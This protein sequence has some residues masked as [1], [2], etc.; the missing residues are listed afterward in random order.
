MKTPFENY[1][2]VM[3]TGRVKVIHSVG[4][5]A[6]I[7]MISLSNKYTGA[8]SETSI[9]LLRA[10]FIAKPEANLAR[11]GIALKILRSKVMSAN[12]VA[13]NDAAGQKEFD[14]FKNDMKNHVKSPMDIQLKIGS[15]KFIQ[16]TNC[17]NTVGLMDFSTH[18]RDGTPVTNFKYPFLIIF[19]PKYHMSTINSA[20]KYNY[21][22]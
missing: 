13:F 22:G 7:K 2:D 19:V 9:G 11:I 16:G 8:F 3:V 15:F 14:F 12:V 21:E 5:V 18:T 10:G 1:A 20:E 17:I 6:K 4:Y